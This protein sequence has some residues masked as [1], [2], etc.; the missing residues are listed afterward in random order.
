MA[1]AY[2]VWAIL[3]FILSCGEHSDDFAVA[4]QIPEVFV[5]R[6]DP[7]LSDAGDDLDPTKIPGDVQHRDQ[8]RQQVRNGLRVQ[9]C[10]HANEA[11]DLADPDIPNV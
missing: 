1:V 10:P 4:S 7:R 6:S 11:I 3:A 8:E 9:V 2:R 5:T